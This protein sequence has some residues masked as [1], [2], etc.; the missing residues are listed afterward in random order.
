M[1][2]HVSA[3]GNP[4]GGPRENSTKE[5]RSARTNNPDVINVF[6]PLFTAVAI[7]PL[8]KRVLGRNQTRI[9]QFFSTDASFEVAYTTTHPPI[10]PTTDS[11]PGDHRSCHR[12]SYL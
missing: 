10:S 4:R 1:Q 11:S 9:R 6:E 12:P 8:T 3:L 7:E 2:G 5:L